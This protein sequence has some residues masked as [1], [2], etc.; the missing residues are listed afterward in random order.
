MCGILGAATSRQSELALNDSTLE[1]LRDTLR[2]RGPD[3]AGLWRNRHVAL[4]HRR[5]AI[6]DPEQGH[7]PFHVGEPDTPGHVV[8]SYNGEI[9]NH[10]TLR[11]ELEALGHVFATRCD[12]ETVAR[13]FA[14]WGADAFGRFR[15]MFAVAAW[16]HDDNTLTL[17]RDPLG[18]KPLYY[19]LAPTPNGAELVFASEPPAILEHPYMPAQPDWVTVSSYLTTIRTTLGRRTLYDGLSCVMPGEIITADLN[20]Q[21]PQLTTDFQPR[22]NASA[23]DDLDEAI[24]HTR[25]LITDSVRAHLLS[26][27]TTCTLLSGGLDS[28]IISAVAADHLDDLHTYCSGA[29]GPDNG[30]DFHF[31]RLTSQQI[32]TRHTE[33]PVTAEAFAELWPWMIGRM[34]VPLSTPNE[35]AIY[36]VAKELSRHA[37]V[38]L[39][40]EGADELFAGYDAP[41]I[42]FANYLANPF[43]TEGNAITPAAHYLQQTSWVSI[44]LKPQI[45]TADVFNQIDND[46]P[47]IQETHRLFQLSDDDELTMRSCLRAQQHFNLTGLL[48]R[49]DTATMLASVEGRTPY[50][51]TH[52]AA[53]AQAQPFDFHFAPKATNTRPTRSKRLLREAFAERLPEP[54]AVRPKASFPLP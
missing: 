9:Y 54:V 19:A 37:K 7:Q 21:P 39:S 48:G 18:V 33:A 49:L 4:T 40:G 17:A 14:Q 15:G 2:H 3:G 38:A 44:A 43:D 25:G 53:F 36:T 31:A 5:L 26:D 22:P 51:D 6:L 16:R 20:Q 46:M 34:G 52:V 11:D 29:H 13:A 50:A 1:R 47:L 8:I 45:L 35:V 42:D 32:N 12:T 10:L 27:V 30:D 28:S 41:L 23:F 24:D